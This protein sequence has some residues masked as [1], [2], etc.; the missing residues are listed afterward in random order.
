M[1][2]GTKQLA[3][4]LNGNRILEV[5]YY[6]R[7]YV[8]KEE[9]WER[10]LSDMEYISGTG[11][12]YFL[13][14]IILKQQPTGISQFDRQTIIDGQQ[15]FTTLALFFKSLCIKTDDMETFE[16][17][18]TVRDRKEKKRLLAIS[19]SINDRNDF[20]RVIA[21]KE[22]EQILVTPQS[23]I[24]N[25]YNYFQANIDPDKLDVDLLLSHVIFIGISLHPDED[26]QLIFDTINSLGVRLT[27]GELLKN[28][29][30][31]ESTREEYEQL[32]MPIFEK[33]REISNYWDAEVTS[34]RLKRANIDFFF[35][36]YLNIKIQDPALKVS[37][38][39]KVRYRRYEGLFNSYKDLISTY[40]LDKKDMIYDI[41]EYAILY[42][43]NI[44]PAIVSQELPATYG[45]ERIN[46]I[47]FALD[48]TTI[49][50]YVL[51]LLHH[52]KNTDERNAMFG[53]I[54]GYILRR[55]ICKSANNNFSDLFAENLISNQ[56]QTLEDLMDYI[57]NK[58]A[59]QTL[60]MPSD[61]AVRIACH[62]HSYPNKKALAILYMLES[63]LRADNLHATKLYSFDR[64]SLEHLMPK[65]WQDNWPLPSNITEEQR[66]NAV[67]CLGNLAMLPGK[68][69]TSI[70]NASWPVKKS[71]KGNKYG[72]SYYASDIE[73]LSGAIASLEWNEAT[74]SER[75]DWLA[76]KINEIWPSYIPEEEADSEENSLH[77]YSTID[78]N[79]SLTRKKN[80]NHDKTRFS[81]N[82][83]P[84]TSKRQFVLNVVKAYLDKYPESTF[85]QLKKVFSEDLCTRGHIHIGLLCSED[86]F[87]AW[88]NKYKNKR[89]TVTDPDG[90]LRS[91]DGI[92]FYVNTQWSIDGITGIINLAR[93]LGF[94]VTPITP[95]DSS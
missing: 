76:T 2:A 47:I 70:S 33:D 34:G 17:K 1:D 75:A 93:S 38:D 4:I 30:F 62:T 87:I 91:S 80:Y 12:D 52:V 66:D 63:S 3:D 58:D 10:F 54:E 50:P 73:T 77:S 29:F 6:Q 92:Y 81:L 26:E 60:V 49:V 88:N 28:Y 85:A 56:I 94:K 36:A 46:F 89:Y 39:H 48:Y 37:T 25:A 90:K 8:W 21:Q 35:T 45:I 20:E 44:N 7:S 15:R 71:G 74:I 67:S 16:S 40:G 78:E 84:V 61:K 18:F 24:I 19:H 5:P 42:H 22:D 83:G 9:Q 43:D 69:N 72:I 32:W 64:Y 11:K 95:R 51:Y 86:A 53:Y 57:E 41:L 27:T 13:G 65:G 31:T 55:L 79:L 82:D 68:L 14:S 59:G 23:N